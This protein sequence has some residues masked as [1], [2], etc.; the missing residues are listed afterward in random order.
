M[1]PTAKNSARHHNP[2]CGLLVSIP[3][4][5]RR[6]L[7]CPLPEGGISR[8]RRCVRTAAGALQLERGD[9]KAGIANKGWWR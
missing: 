8:S 6:R 2:T 1:D 4:N 7:A 3:I 5:L 9:G